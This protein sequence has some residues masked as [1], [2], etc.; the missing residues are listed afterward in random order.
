MRQWSGTLVDA[1]HDRE[2]EMKPM[3]E[4]ILLKHVADCLEEAQAY[5]GKGN[6][7]LADWWH[8]RA[9]MYADSLAMYR[10]VEKLAAHRQ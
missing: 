3:S 5:V 2:L 10:E 7:P 9:D 8:S 6:R 4:S 1:I